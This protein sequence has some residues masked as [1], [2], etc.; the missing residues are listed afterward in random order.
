MVII[1]GLYLRVVRIL[2]NA[3]L[4]ILG[5]ES[6]LDR[7]QGQRTP[8]PIYLP[9]K[10][11]VGGLGRTEVQRDRE[12]KTFKLSTNLISKFIGNKNKS[13]LRI[14]ILGASGLK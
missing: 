5:R 11:G 1:S 14:G 7:S 12:R 13:H 2:S 4:H 10:Y 8:A 9:Q 6:I 3:F